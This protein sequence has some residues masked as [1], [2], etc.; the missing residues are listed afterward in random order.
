MSKNY[1]KIFSEYYLSQAQGGAGF[2]NIY[3]G[4][5]FQSG[6]GIGSFLGGLFRSVWPILK[7]GVNTVGKQSLKTAANIL[8]DISDNKNFKQS[9]NERSKEGARVLTNK[10]IN[11][12]KGEG[13]SNN[14]TRTNKR[15]RQIS[16]KRKSSSKTSNAKKK[17]STKTNK[18]K[19]LCESDIFS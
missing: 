2:T 18:R 3:S 16:T 14:S 9:L 6:N 10:L 8:T 11:T 19:K 1:D 5:S 15:K 17:K 13:I 7:R 4:P 12:M